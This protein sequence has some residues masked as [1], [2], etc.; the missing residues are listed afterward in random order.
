M[1]KKVTD[2]Q[3]EYLDPTHVEIAGKPCAGMTIRAATGSVLGDLHGFLIDPI[4]RKL[5]YLVVGTLNRERFLPF[6]A[7]R[8]DT[9]RGEIEIKADEHD[10]RRAG[11]VFPGL[12]MLG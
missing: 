4:A 10:F 9:A 6:S 7:A 11:D 3:L 8:V 2:G 12:A 1:T 5:L